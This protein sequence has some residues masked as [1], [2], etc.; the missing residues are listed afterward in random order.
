MTNTRQVLEGQDNNIQIIQQ[1]IFLM[2]VY[3]GQT[4]LVKSWLETK[5]IVNIDC[6]FTGDGAQTDSKIKELDK[7]HGLTALMIAAVGGHQEIT[8]LLL[9]HGANINAT[10]RGDN[11]TALMHAA[12]ENH[13]RIAKLLLQK[14]AKSDLK[15]NTG[16][17]AYDYA[18]LNKHIDM[19]LIIERKGKDTLLEQAEKYPHFTSDI[20]EEYLCPISIEL[21]NE[22]IT[23]PTG[24]TYDRSSLLALFYHAR[25]PQT[26][27]LPSTIVCPNTQK[28]LRAEV[29]S[30]GI[31]III[32]KII[33]T[34][35]EQEIAIAK[36][37]AK[38]AAPKNNVQ[39]AEE[40]QQHLSECGIGLFSAN[41]PTPTSPGSP[42]QSNAFANK[43]A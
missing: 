18:S 16:K 7:E 41:P 28:P 9:D 2:A 1:N 19:M 30:F 22:P 21:M 6:T 5:K 15:N 35:V 42:V 38:E 23:V 40:E 37:I 36:K 27:A 25:D 11:H 32:K 33:T 43:G 8:A 14:G 3:K 31:N 17:T 13:T 20:P 10:S 24:H 26:L 39:K 4:A 12:K 29:L 34:F